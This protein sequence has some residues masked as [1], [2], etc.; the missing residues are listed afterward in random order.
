[1]RP[2][3]TAPP[4]RSRT[5]QSDPQ[6]PVAQARRQ[7]QL[8]L[9]IT[10]DEVQRHREFVL[11]RPDVHAGRSAADTKT[12]AHEQARSHPPRWHALVLCAVGLVVGFGLAAAG[13]PLWTALP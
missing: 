12:D 11:I 4:R 10:L 7:Q 8:L 5:R 3:P 13:L 2:D 1:M 9:A 6:A